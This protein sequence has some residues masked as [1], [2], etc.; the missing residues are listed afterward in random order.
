MLDFSEGKGLF[1]T[2]HRRRQGSGE[3]VHA[4]WSNCSELAVSS[5]LKYEAV[6]SELA[7]FPAHGRPERGDSAGRTHNPGGRRPPG[8]R[9]RVVGFVVRFRSALAGQVLRIPP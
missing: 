2:R 9:R 1:I 8:R 7:V 6:I 5:L 3:T 4:V